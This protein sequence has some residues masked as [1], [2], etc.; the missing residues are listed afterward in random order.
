MSG[1]CYVGLECTVCGKTYAE[2]SI[3]VCPSCGGVLTGKYDLG[4][5]NIRIERGRSIWQF[6]DLFPPISHKNRVS[7]D[8]G[9]TPYVRLESYGKLIGVRDL[10]GKLEGQNPTGSFKDRAAS[11]L[12]SLVKEWGKQGVFTAS[13]GNAAAAIAAYAARGGVSALILVREDAPTS[14]LAQISMYHPE[15]IRVKDLFRTK[16]TLLGFLQSV[17]GVL[18]GWQN[19]FLWAPCNPLT[20]DGIKS[21]SYEIASNNTPDYVFV[22]T[23]GG[24]LLYSVYKGFKELVELGLA[25]H[26]PKMVAVQGEGAAPLV[27]AVEKG[28]EH[29]VDTERADTIAGAL[30]V[31]FGSDHALKAIN[32]SGGFAVGVSDE[33][34][35][36]AQ[37]QLAQLDG[38]FAEISSCAALA[39]VKK[40]ALTGKIGADESIA[41]ILTGNGF[42]DY[43]PRLGSASELPLVNSVEELRGML[44]L[45]EASNNL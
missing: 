24:D 10:W 28:L 27:N 45:G 42:K 12:I 21:I 40:A 36:E 37:R 25:T 8:E 43:Y 11:L 41:V 19:G 7:L 39:A 33:E 3:K 18:H 1:K 17:E 44:S 15:I 34:I 31:N 38:V 4:G 20:V 32:G 35:V 30:R 9:W 13:S 2:V 26:I 23:A 22:P 6:E 29:V 5:A 16:Q 14:K